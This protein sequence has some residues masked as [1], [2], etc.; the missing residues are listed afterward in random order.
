MSHRI[1]LSIFFILL[2]VS[3]SNLKA[4]DGEINTL[5][6]GGGIYS[7][8]GYGSF[9]M[10][11]GQLDGLN[12]FSFGGQGGWIINHS[13]VIGGGGQGFSSEYRY[14]EHLDGR[15]QFQGGYGGLLLEFI[16]K[17]TSI[18]H[19]N[20]PMLIGGGGVRYT[21]DGKSSSSLLQEDDA[22]FFIFEPGFDIQVN[23]LPFMRI[24]L[25][26]RFRITSDASLRYLD[27]R[28]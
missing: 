23:L 11:Y 16:L 5:F 2:F 18:V 14:D 19:F 26:G 7:S 4:Q 10:S 24:A 9:N 17:P 6:S 12:T 8:G 13:F 22:S 15:Y 20:I 27:T 21:L 3:V 1:C 28:T 25:G